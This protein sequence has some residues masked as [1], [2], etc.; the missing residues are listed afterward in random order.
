MAVILLSFC[1]LLPLAR[2]SKPKYNTVGEEETK[3]IPVQWVHNSWK[4]STK[5]DFF[6]Y[7]AKIEA[8]LSKCQQI[9]DM[10]I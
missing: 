1:S 7:M 6:D 10:H 4:M 9:M 3:R 2:A 8:V 5:A